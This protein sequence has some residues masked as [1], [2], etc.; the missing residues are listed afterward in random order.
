MKPFTPFQL[1]GGILLPLLFCVSIDLNGQAGN[2]I[3]YE[4]ELQKDKEDYDNTKNDSPCTEF[5]EL[6]STVNVW[7]WRAETYDIV[8][9]PGNSTGPAF[10][11]VPSPFFSFG[12]NTGHLAVVENGQRDFEPVDGWELLYQNFGTEQ[13]P[14][15][16]PSYG[17]Y[18][19]L[20]GRFR[21]FYHIETN[22]GQLIG[23]LLLRLSMTDPNSSQNSAALFENLNIPANALNDFDQRVSAGGIVQLNRGFASGQWY[24]LEGVAGYDP[25]SCKHQSALRVSPVFTQYNSLT[26]LGEG[27]N[28]PTE[29]FDAG[30]PVA[31]VGFFNGVNQSVNT[32]YKH[33]SSY[34]RYTAEAATNRA[35]SVDV[36]SKYLPPFAAESSQNNEVTRLLGFVTGMNADN[37]S[38]RIT[39]FNPNFNFTA[40]GTLVPFARYDPYFMYTPGSL[41]LATQ[42]Q[43]YRT[44]YDNPLGLLTVLEAPVVERQRTNALPGQNNEATYRWRFA[45][46][47]RYHVNSLAGIEEQPVALMASLVWTSECSTEDRFYATPAINISCLEELVVTTGDLR[48]LYTEDGRVCDVATLD[49]CLGEPE[50]QIAA[51][52]L[53]ENPTPGRQ[54]LFSAR[55]KT[56]VTEVPAGTIGDNPFAGMT[57]QEIDDNCTGTVPGPVNDL[58]LSS[59]C[60]QQ[61]D[62]TF[63]ASELAGDQPDTDG[64]TAPV[65]F[66]AFPNPFADQLSIRVPEEWR[67]RTLRFQF[68]DVL[69]RLLRERE[70]VTCTTGEYVIANDLGDLPNGNYVLTVSGDDFVTSLA[71]QKR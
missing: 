4:P 56:T 17:L 19:R 57:I 71:V 21:I 34:N 25:C 7:D 69:G 27:T 18:N 49:D 20:D 30:E 59:F 14:V 35:T 51:V 6:G 28:E 38:S 58:D 68:Y 8:Y 33:Y 65:V 11:T 52:L 16:E 23:N 54:M 13:R 64:E 63:R 36:L 5:T 45:G 48:E 42:I 1:L 66:A 61:Y 62:P 31:A 47:L 9:Y 55:Y 41:R 22:N 37:T 43:R 60:N 12:P 26:F 70:G 46:D 15:Q 44:V 40:N 32:G 53:S 24:L 3:P 39:A 67:N 29:T 10:R 50:L 2:E